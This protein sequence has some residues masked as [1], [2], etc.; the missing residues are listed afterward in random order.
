MLLVFSILFS[1]EIQAQYTDFEHDG[2]TRQYIYYE[3]E[4]LNQ[5]MPLVIVMHGYG[6]DANSIRNYSEMNQFADQYGFA[7][8][9][10]RGTVDME[11]IDC[12]M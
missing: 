7:V 9:Y 4:T 1:L 2:D 8:C 3:P 10:P 11:E 6:G 5:Q 12:G